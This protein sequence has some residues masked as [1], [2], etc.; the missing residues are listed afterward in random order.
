MNALT[1]HSFKKSDIFH[2]VERS[3][4]NVKW[5]CKLPKTH[6]AVKSYMIR[7][8][9]EYPTAFAVGHGELFNAFVEKWEAGQLRSAP[10]MAKNDGKAGASF[11]SEDEVGEIWA[12]IR[13]ASRVHLLHTQYTHKEWIAMRCVCRVPL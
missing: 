6:A 5:T 3:D 12:F 2:V 11:P 10:L 9:T 4:L 7:D 8:K 1:S 13:G